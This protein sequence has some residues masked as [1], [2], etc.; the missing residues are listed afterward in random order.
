MVL[1]FLP[2]VIPK[3][4]VLS[5]A[6]C[7]QKQ[8]QN[9]KAP[10]PRR[11][12]KYI[13]WLTL[14][15]N[16]YFTLY[17]IYV[18]C[19]GAKPSSAQG[20]ILS[21]QGSFLAGS[22]MIRG[23]QDWTWV[24]SVQDKCPTFCPVTLA[25]I[26]GLNPFSP[27]SEFPKWPIFSVI[28]ARESLKRSVSSVLAQLIMGHNKGNNLPNQSRICLPKLSLPPEIPWKLLTFQISLSF[29]QVHCN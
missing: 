13:S 28:S 26:T 9:R 8:K 6:G 11:N 7:G 27:A 18:F 17:R 3:C 24:C 1:P 16:L 20:L 29:T 15:T 5:T 21:T 25:L 4:R 19:L 14:Y 12:V 23:A 10:P 2:G 22:G